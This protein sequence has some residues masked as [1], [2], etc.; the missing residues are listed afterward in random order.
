MDRRIVLKPVVYA[1]LS[2]LLLWWA[3]AALALA[4]GALQVHSALGEPLAARIALFSVSAAERQSLQVRLG[5]ERAYRRHGVRRAAVINAIDVQVVQGAAAGGGV[6]LQL[7]SAQPIAAPLLEM[8]VVAETGDG[9]AVRKYTALLNPPS[10][11]PARAKPTAPQATKRPRSVTVTVAPQQT[12]WRIAKRHKYAGV[13]IEQMLVAI[14]RANPGAFDGD[15]SN[16]R[17]GSTLVMPSPDT[18]R[19]IDPAWAENWVESRT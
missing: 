15:I 5:G 9:R 16:M 1:G 4:L 17:V 8:L 6:T 19:D 2:S 14:Y 12:L 10:A 3:P 13:S 7:T 11:A 18:V